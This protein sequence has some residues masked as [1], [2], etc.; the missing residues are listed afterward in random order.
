MILLGALPSIKPNRA[1]PLPHDMDLRHAIRVYQFAER[2]KSELI[3][4]N[5]LIQEVSTIGDESPGGRRVLLAY[6]GA[7]HMEADLA[8][9][10]TKSQ[11]FASIAQN[12]ATAADFVNLLN[13]PEASKA[14]TEALTS[15]TS[16][17]GEAAQILIENNLL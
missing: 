2:L 10:T 9:N 1:Q 15:S 7:V 13:F 5:N 17:A 16:A 6:L 3:I 8:V 4:A 14:T 12:I 11:H